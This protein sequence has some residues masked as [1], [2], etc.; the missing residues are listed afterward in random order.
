VEKKAKTALKL[1]ITKYDKQMNEIMFSFA[2]KS[3]SAIATLMA[4]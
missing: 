2:T 1:Q 3:L 4:D